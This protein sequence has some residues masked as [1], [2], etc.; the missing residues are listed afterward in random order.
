VIILEH[1]SFELLQ[2]L[3]AER[4]AVVPIDSLLYA[5]LAVNMPTTSDVT[6]VYRVQTYR[7][8]ELV[9]QLVGGDAEGVIVQLVYHGLIL[10]YYY[11]KYR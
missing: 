4:T 9:L 7:A 6:V 3:G 11:I 5:M 10:C 1:V 2:I 8:L